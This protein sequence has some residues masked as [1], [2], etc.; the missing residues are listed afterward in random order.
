MS[1]TQETAPAWKSEKLFNPPGTG[2]IWQADGEEY[3]VAECD[4][5][6]LDA[7]D[8]GDRAAEMVRRWNAYPDLVAALRRAEQFIVNGIEFGAIRMPSGEDDPAHETLPAIRAA[9]KAGA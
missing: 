9:L 3:K 5:H 2:L 1:E 8:D 7:T 4:S 6:G